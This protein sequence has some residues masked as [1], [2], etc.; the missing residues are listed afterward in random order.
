M[1]VVMPLTLDTE[2][3]K[4]IQ[5]KA[6]SHSQINCFVFSRSINVSVP[7]DNYDGLYTLEPRSGTI[8]RFGP[9]EVGVSLWLWAIRHSP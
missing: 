4:E 9:V 6:Y 8:R 2:K 7:N 1:N 5:E 3:M